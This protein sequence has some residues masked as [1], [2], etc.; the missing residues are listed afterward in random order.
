VVVLGTVVRSGRTQ[1]LVAPI[2]HTAPER[3]ADAIEI[4]ANVKSQLG[5][6]A[7]RSWIVVTELNRFIWPGPDLRKVPGRD[8]PFYDMLPDWLFVR[9]R[10]AL[11]DHARAG[12]LTI[13]KRTE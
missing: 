13:T 12:R 7:D 8:D 1:L 6:D 5:L 3:G 9:V 11:I 2:T 4:P 10:N